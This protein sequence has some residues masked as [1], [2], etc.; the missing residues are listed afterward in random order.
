MTLHNTHFALESLDLMRLKNYLRNTG[1]THYGTTKIGVE[2]WTFKHDDSDLK[3]VLIADQTFDDYR[4]GIQTVLRTLSEIEGRTEQAILDQIM[5]I[6]H[7]VIRF[8]SMHSLA[9]HGQIPLVDG[10]KLYQGA[11]E[12]LLSAATV[13]ENKRPILPNR[14]PNA[15][16]DFIEQAQI[17]QTEIG[18]YVLVIHAPFQT[19]AEVGDDP[20]LKVPYSRRVL[21]TLANALDYLSGVSSRVDPE[22]DGESIIEN[23]L[24]HF[25][26]LGGSADLCRALLQLQESAEDQP[27]EISLAW[28]DRIP[29]RDLPH[30]HFVI[31]PRISQMA[32]RIERTLQRKWNEELKTITGWVTRL[33]SETSDGSIA[34]ISIKG[35]IDQLE[36]TVRLTIMNDADYDIALKA[37]SSKR[38]SKVMCRG[39]LV[40]HANHTAMEHYIDFKILE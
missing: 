7:D 6:E 24:S 26:D 3:R 35:Q 38:K 14:K 37:L 17:G 40:K 13:V 10:M 28:S 31:T 32:K 33:N 19:D 15:A 12:A 16:L 18:S 27:V 4:E 11:Y 25:V 5:G 29:K 1:W 21:E 8:R 30:S 36:R 22:S 23:H 9:M 2:T 39:Q 34:T 20:D